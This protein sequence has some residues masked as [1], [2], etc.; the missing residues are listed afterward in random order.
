AACRQRM[1]MIRAIAGRDDQRIRGPAPLVDDD[2]VVARQSAGQRELDVG[3]DADADDRDVAGEPP[4]AGGLDRLDAL[5]A[6]ETRDDRPTLD[7]DARVAVIALVE[8]ADR[9]A[10][11][12]AHH[13][14]RG[15]EH[16]DVE[17]AAHGDG[18]DLEAD[19]AGADEH[20]TPSRH[21]LGRY[22]VDV[23]DRPQIVDPGEL[24]AWHGEPARFASGREDQSV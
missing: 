2:A 11:D 14:I 8:L 6:D 3:L 19:I 24:R 18:S 1:R 13:A 15:L 22:R 23:V 12:A 10:D 4:P 21:E 7:L 17:P 20:E 5:A 16:R 9:G